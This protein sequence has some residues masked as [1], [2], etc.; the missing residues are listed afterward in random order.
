M[1]AQN[2]TV[3]A[4]RF[5]PEQLQ[6]YLASITLR[7]G[8]GASA[9]DVCVMQAVDYIA[10]GGTSDQPECASPVITAFMIGLNDRLNDERRQR[11][12]RFIPQ[13]VGTRGTMVL[14]EELIGRLIAVGKEQAS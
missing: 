9:D 5:S 13:L 12:K 8:S 10:S 14:A 3:A 11:L 6:Q 4:I 2:S 1:T 7:S